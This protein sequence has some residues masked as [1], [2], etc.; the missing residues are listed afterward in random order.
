[1]SHSA[2]ARPT[3]QAGPTPPAGPDDVQ[4][5]EVQPVEVRLYNYDRPPVRP[6]VPGDTV[7]H[8]GTRVLGLLFTGLVAYDPADGSAHEAVARSI[9][10]Q[11]ATTFTVSLHPGWTFHD[12]TPVT[13]ASFVDAW[14][15]TAHAANRQAGA[16]A[17][18]KVLGYH[19]VHPATGEPTAERMRGLTVLDELTF[20]VTLAEPFGLFPV[21]L[22]AAAYLPLPARYF[23]DRAG[24]LASPV[25]NGPYRLVEAGPAELRLT[26]HQPYPGPFV[27]LVRDLR[28]ISYPNRESAYRALLAGELDYLEALPHALVADGGAER[29]LAGRITG[30]DGL[31]LQALAFPSYLPGYDSPEL[32]KA[33]SLAIDR[34]RVVRRALGGRQRIA[35]GWSVPGIPGHLPGQ[36]GPYCRHDPEAARELLARSG[37][38]GPLE[39][40]S[41]ASAEGW[42]GEIAACLTETLG[43]ACELVLYDTVRGYADA[44]ADRTVTGIVRADWAADY[45][46]LENFLR[47]QFHSRSPSNES[48]YHRPEFDALLAEAD[49]T[50]DPGAATFRYQQAE[51][52]LAEDLPHVPLWQ[53]WAVAG[54]SARLSRVAMT[55]QGELDLRTV[56]VTP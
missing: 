50:P 21:M 8:C 52:L 1:M 18:E 5:T 24:Y 47:P 41:P 33:V 12:G 19:E 31:E 37:F 38:T 36:A 22:G 7:E 27:P 44:V 13:A 30:R 35:D 48:G 20:T 42:L 17:F 23:T 39:F 4:P 14:N 53:E 54:Y 29:E 15:H 16:T 2:E 55:C 49:R 28:L 43:L 9:T 32:R 10:S 25:G 51:R 3:L 46:A 11:D 34:E 26:R 56:L 45:P 6:L 40:H